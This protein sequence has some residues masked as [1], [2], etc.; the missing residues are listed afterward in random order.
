LLR[1]GWGGDDAFHGAWRPV[2]LE[3][4]VETV[5]QRWNPPVKI[6]WQKISS[7]PDKNWAGIKMFGYECLPKT[8]IA[9]DLEAAGIAI[10]GPDAPLHGWKRLTDKALMRSTVSTSRSWQGY[11][12]AKRAEL[13][14][15]VHEPEYFQLVRSQLEELRHHWR[16]KGPAA[17]EFLRRRP[18]PAIVNRKSKLFPKASVRFRQILSFLIGSDAIFIGF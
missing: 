9:K 13:E 10:D 8:A 5:K 11:H 4:F 6:E 12:E 3:R 18:V 2:N 7:K 16:G 1:G 17:R 15:F 14:A